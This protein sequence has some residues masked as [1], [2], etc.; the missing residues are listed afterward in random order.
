MAKVPDTESIFILVDIK[1]KYGAGLITFQTCLRYRG[2]GG[3]NVIGQRL[4][5]FYAQYDRYVSN[6]IFS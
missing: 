4:R 1:A 5:Q 6:N 3:I 2:N